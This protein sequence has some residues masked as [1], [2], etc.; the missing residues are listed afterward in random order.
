[1]GATTASTGAFTTLSATGVTTVQ[2]GSAAS[3]AITTT[4]DTN[5]GIF[6]PAADT[7]CFSE[8]G[9][10]AMR[11]DS[12]G[13]VG[14][15]TT[16]SAWF[17]TYRALV[18][19]YANNGM[20]SGGDVQLGLTQNAFLDSGV[21]WRYT[22]SNPA[23]QYIQINSAH[24]WFTAPSGTAGNAISFTQAMTLDASG[25]LGI[26]TSSPS[27]KLTIEASGAAFP[28]TS[29]PSVRL[30]ETSSGRF[31]VMELDSSQNLNFWNGDTGSGLTRFYR[32]SGSGTLS[33][34]I[35]GAGNTTFAGNISVGGATVTT[36]GTGITFPATQSPS[37]DANTLDDY[38][39][40][41][42]GS[43][44]ANGILTPST[45]GSITCAS[46]FS[47]TYTKIGRQVTCQGQIVVSSVSSPVGFIQ[48][49]LPFTQLS[50]TNAIGCGT[51]ISYNIDLPTGAVSNGMTSQ[52]GNVTFCWPR[53][54]VDNA[55]YAN[56]DSALLIA[57]SEIQFIFSFITS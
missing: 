16:P 22:T 34:A 21:S 9:L 57:G 36:S 37:S 2:A 46:T 51:F 19:G 29:N 25:N 38:E 10:E 31:A 18:L 28:S 13:N 48:I 45:S 23:S 1:V 14:V 43:S 20:F 52:T 41:T 7:I 26:G 42:Y 12:A 49:A 5:T 40:G 32:G 54:S 50:A 6:F 56:V 55:P 44:S 17:S 53:V 3:P 11:I 30:N 27:R 35:D 39:E 47:C 4:G 15:G 24:Q 33:M 8:G